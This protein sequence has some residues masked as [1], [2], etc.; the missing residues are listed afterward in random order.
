MS[1]EVRPINT[2]SHYC[3]GKVN[4]RYLRAYRQRRIARYRWLLNQS[5]HRW[6]TNYST[7]H[8]G[9]SLPGTLVDGNAPLPEAT[10]HSDVS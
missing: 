10:W 3:W 8:Q 7:E 2:I 4:R 1:S 9:V 6:A 5:F